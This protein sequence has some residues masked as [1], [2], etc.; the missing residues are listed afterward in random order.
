MAN[1]RAVATA[2]ELA[3]GNPESS[4]PCPC[5]AASLKASNLQKH[6]RKVHQIEEP[7][8]RPAGT[9]VFKGVDM[10][11]RLEL[12]VVFGVFMATLFAH[13]M[14]GGQ[15]QGGGAVAIGV[16]F[17]AVF[18][19]WCAALAG[20]LPATLELEGD[21]F[22][23]RYALGARSRTVRLP[24]Q[25]ELGRLVKRRAHDNA[26]PVTT[27]GNIAGE[28]MDAG[29]FLRIYNDGGSIT[30]GSDK[31]TAPRKHWRGWTN[32]PKRRSWEISLQRE[33]MVALQYLL[34]EHRVL[35]INTSEVEGPP[36]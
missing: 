25:V 27:G 13:I 26:Y 6:L 20:W 15:P 2:L 31:G 34:A 28:D 23:V 35:E 4:L 32:A 33:D 19:P 29:R 3:A 5:C 24:A 17:A 10:R 21:V 12:G 1:P 8:E 16:A 30:V 36:G 9:Q 14:A 22:R 7:T 11:T 18:L